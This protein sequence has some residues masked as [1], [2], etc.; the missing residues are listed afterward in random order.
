MKAGYESA[1]GGQE[2]GLLQ[3]RNPFRIFYGLNQGGYT[4]NIR[5][6]EYRP[7]I[8]SETGFLFAGTDISLIEVVSLL[9]LISFHA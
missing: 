2:Y 6:P 5:Q 7:V 1:R 3:K 9:T 8:S 4:F